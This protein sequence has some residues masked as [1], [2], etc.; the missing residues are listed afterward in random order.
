MDI[1]E[2][3]CGLT[4]GVWCV[5]PACHSQSASYDLILIIQCSLRFFDT[6][7]IGGALSSS[8]HILRDWRMG[9]H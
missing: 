8:K 1:R 4:C 6:T 2:R 7:E 5:G 3:Y 9:G